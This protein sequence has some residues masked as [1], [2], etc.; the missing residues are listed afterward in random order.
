MDCLIS[1]AFR[2]VVQLTAPSSSL[3][4]S[5]RRSVSWRPLLPCS[6]RG[7]AWLPASLRGA[8][9][10]TVRK[11]NRPSANPTPWWLRSRSLC[12]RL[13]CLPRPALA[14]QSQNKM[15][16][17]LIPSFGNDRRFSGA[18]TRTRSF[19]TEIDE[20]SNP[21]G[22]SFKR[23]VR[24]ETSEDVVVPG[25]E[26]KRGIFATRGALNGSAVRVVSRSRSVVF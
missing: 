12:C 2:R 13:S 7:V 1:E 20:E 26:G 3:C 11:K 15:D 4:V 17:N 25:R 10:D 14:R 18:L 6:L 8:H 23:K 24:T 9:D 5:S 16:S 19:V 22:P 21:G